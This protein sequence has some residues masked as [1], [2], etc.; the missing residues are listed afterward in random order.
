VK[1]TRK[2]SDPVKKP[3]ADVEPTALTYHVKVDLALKGRCTVGGRPGTCSGSLTGTAFA[4][5]AVK[6]S[7]VELKWR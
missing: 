6:G 1:W 7:K 5:V 3:S 4:R 2:G